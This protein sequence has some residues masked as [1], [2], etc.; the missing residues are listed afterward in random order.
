MFGR[1]TFE[2][3]IQLLP[4]QTGTIFIIPKM[5]ILKRYLGQKDKRMYGM[6]DR[7]KYIYKSFEL[8]LI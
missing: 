5:L 6:I 7:Q 3:Q 1:V 2:I 4:F 8:L